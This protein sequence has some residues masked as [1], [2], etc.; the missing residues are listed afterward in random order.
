MIRE[1][2]EQNSVERGKA[3]QKHQTKE[4]HNDTHINAWL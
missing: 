3:V 1:I 4:C 2:S